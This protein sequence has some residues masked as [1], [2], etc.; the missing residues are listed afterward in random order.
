MLLR[1]A[2]GEKSSGR[3][4]WSPEEPNIIGRATGEIRND[5]APL[6]DV[7]FIVMKC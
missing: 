4:G 2:N 7:S 1:L 6:D 3:L 5:H